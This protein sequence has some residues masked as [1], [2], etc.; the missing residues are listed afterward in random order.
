MHNEELGLLKREIS[1]LYQSL[2]DNNKVILDSRIQSMPV[3]PN[4]PRIT[5]SLSKPS[6]F[7]AKH[8][9]TISKYICCAIHGL[10]HP[11]L[12][13]PSAHPHPTLPTPPHPTPPTFSHPN[14]LLP[15]PTPAQP[16]PPHP[17][18]T[19]LAPPCHTHTAPPRPAHI[20]AYLV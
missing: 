18:A 16:S 14:P 8:W 6:I 5:V 19:H 9:I 2:S 12:P 20:H 13:C 11:T 17:T 10:L 7:K 1:A 3:V 4:F 15:H